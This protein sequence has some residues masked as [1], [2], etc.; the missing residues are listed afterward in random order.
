[1]KIRFIR[2]VQA[3]TEGRHKGPVYKAGSEHD[4]PLASAERWLRRG[5]AVEVTASARVKPERPM[6]GAKPAAE[7]APPKADADAEPAPAAAPK[8]GRKAKK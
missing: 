3:E 7:A 6:M 8:R 2:T 1:M 4:F 5:V